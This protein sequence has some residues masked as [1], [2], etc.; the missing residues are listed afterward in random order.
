MKIRRLEDLQ[1]CVDKEMAWRRKE[2]TSVKATIKTS[3]SF[4]KN[5]AIR[6][7]VAL[8]YSHWEGAVKNIATY[9]LEYVSRKQLCYS[10]LKPCFLAVSIKKDV[11]QFENSNK[12]TLHSQIVCNVL[13]K[14][15]EKSNIPYDGIIKTNANLNSKV[16]KEIFATIGLPIDAY[17]S[18]FNFID[19]VLLAKRNCIAHGE[20]LDIL[21]LDE[22][23]YYQMQQKIVDLL[24]MFVIDVMNAATLEK[25]KSV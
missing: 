10:E 8:L 5:T 20:R 23:R 1:D 3:R 19:E 2:L 12:S 17:E 13:E 9:Y 7:G 18:S 6:A 24:N 14:Q 16:L 11:A 25:Y 22:S 15:K 4:A 21:D